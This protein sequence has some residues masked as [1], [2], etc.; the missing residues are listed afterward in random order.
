MLT[1]S[2]LGASMTLTFFK[3]P[4]IEF[5]LI[6]VSFLTPVV[7]PAASMGSDRWKDSG[8]FFWFRILSGDIEHREAFITT[9]VS[10]G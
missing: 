1:K 4:E 3:R 7:T 10:Q 5:A 9:R 8:C 6:S 2:E